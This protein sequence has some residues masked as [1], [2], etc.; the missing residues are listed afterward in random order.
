[1]ESWRP[2]AA[3][4]R[5]NTLPCVA[6]KQTGSGSGMSDDVVDLQLDRA[7]PAR[8]YDYYLGGHTN[9]L[10]DREAVGRVL[11]HFPSVVVAARANRAFMHRSTRL[12]ADSGLRQFLDIGTGIP[13]QPNLHEIAQRVTPSARIVYIDNDPIVL[14]HAK[15]LLRSNPAGRTAYI[16][17]DLR[18]PAG[19][20]SAPALLETLDLREPIA[21]SLNAVLNFI[22][23][24]RDPHG[25]VEYLKG[26]L[27]PGSALA[28]SMGTADFA[29]RTID[30]GIVEVYRSSGT[31]TQPRSRAETA[32]FF[33]GWS[34]LPP[35]ITTTHRW[36][37]DKPPAE[38]EITDAQV[39]AYAAVARKS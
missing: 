16:Q 25:I 28:I 17:A 34:L 21:L 27:A 23:D 1:M 13:R 22:P 5:I 38:A 7:H 10:A 6:G 37:P 18:D 36:N 29:P 19:I 14:A 4:D 8:M 12:L 39:A 20:L 26:A 33:E 32:R 35:G 11:A 3:H 15:A 9:F 24:D 2:Q 31:P 30:E